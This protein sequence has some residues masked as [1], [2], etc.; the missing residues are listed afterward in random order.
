VSAMHRVKA[1]TVDEYLAAVSDEKRA[2]L[3]ALRKAIRAAAPKAEECISYGIPAFRLN[4][5]MLVWFGGGANHCSFYP[6]AHPIAAC[7]TDLKAYTISKG[8]VRFDIGKPLPASLV[9]KL[10]KARIAEH[11]R[12]SKP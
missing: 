1:Q 7:K 9:K 3:N 5:R 4:G 11:E 2:T 12:R 6:G 10:V 8:T